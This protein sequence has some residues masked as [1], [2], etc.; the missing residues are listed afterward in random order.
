MMIQSLLFWNN[1]T[2]VECI[3]TLHTVVIHF[4]HSDAMYYVFWNPN[5]VFWM[6]NVLCISRVSR[7]KISF[8]VAA[9]GSGQAGQQEVINQFV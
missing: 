8:S 1:C 9:V 5:P 7:E 6:L 2:I 4:H 3:T